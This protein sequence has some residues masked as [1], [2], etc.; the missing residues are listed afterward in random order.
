MSSWPL[1]IAI[2][3]LAGS[4]PFGYLIGQANG[5]DLRVVGSKNIGATNLGRVLGRRFF[6]V[7]FLL[8]ML[9]GLIPTAAA[10]WRM[11]LL[12]EFSMPGDQAWWWL[13]VMAASV[14]GHMY[15]PWLGFKGG[16][17]V[18]TG[19]GAML[20]LFPALTVPAAGTFVV[21]LIVLALW[22]YVS[23]ASIAGAA[24]LPFWAWYAHQQFKTLQERRISSE[25]GFRDVAARD[26]DALVPFAGWPFVIVAGLLGALVI[27]RHRAN[28]ARLAAG[29]EPKIGSAERARSEKTGPP[30]GSAGGIPSD[31]QPPQS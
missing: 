1:F 23:A 17:G 18:A 6:F 27:Y 21:F 16:K 7:C 24:A 22:R 20:G 31:E 14:M 28:I 19:L 3:F 8:D 30:A 10:G 15:T 9:K 13:G 5:V 29:T 25:P 26:I 12:G 2:A 11:G 4:I